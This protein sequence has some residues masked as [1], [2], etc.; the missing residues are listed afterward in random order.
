MTARALVALAGLLVLSP[1]GA[2]AEPGGQSSASH[3]VLSG[4]GHL[5]VG[6]SESTPGDP[7]HTPVVGY[8]TYRVST[9]DHPVPGDL[10]GLCAVDAQR[11]KFGW[12]YRVIGT[13][14]DGRV[15][16]DELVCVPFD[17]THAPHPPAPPRLPTLEEAW[18][19]ANVPAPH[20]ITDPETRGVTGLPTHITATSATQLTIAASVR[21]YRIAGRATLDHFLVSIDGAPPVTTATADIVFATKGDHTIVVAVVWHGRATLTGPDL[22]HPITVN[23]IGVAT[24]GTTRVFAVHEVRSVLQP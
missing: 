3:A 16:V 5:V 21:G 13:T 9:D 8:V 24:I 20:I 7:I 6:V 23:D 17:A 11:T 22:E 14:L 12:S 1:T 18:N 2:G 10:S 4:D 19:A 15:V